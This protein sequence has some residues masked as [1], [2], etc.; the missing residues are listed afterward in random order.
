M[1]DRFGVPAAFLGM[2]EKV[3]HA[4]ELWANGGCQ[5]LKP[6]TAREELG[7]VFKIIDK[8]NKINGPAIPQRC[9]V[10]E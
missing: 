3:P 4:A 10:V 8:P 5:G 7:Q 6:V 1:Q 2:L 9:W